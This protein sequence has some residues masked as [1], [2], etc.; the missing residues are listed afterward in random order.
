MC[1]WSTCIS[2][3]AYMVPA[4]MY[5]ISIYAYVHIRTQ[6]ASTDVGWIDIED[7]LI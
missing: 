1:L 7:G 2:G 4:Y 3:S 6:T 5:C